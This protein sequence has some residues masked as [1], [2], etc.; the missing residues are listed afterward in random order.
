MISNGIEII[1][2]NYRCRMGEIDIIGRDDDT[3]IF[4]EVKYRKSDAYGNALYAI[5]I[6][7]QAKI[8]KVA[9]F[10][11]N[12]SKHKGYARFDAVGITGDKIDWIR[13]AF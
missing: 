6:K 5:D 1:E 12:Y 13:N 8:R 7:K 2:T 11:L 4:F 9:Q 10:Y 3:L